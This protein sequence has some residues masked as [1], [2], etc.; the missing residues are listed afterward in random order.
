M[1][2]HFSTA[3]RLS[4]SSAS[5]GGGPDFRFLPRSVPRLGP[6]S[7]GGAEHAA[8][9]DT[10]AT[11]GGRATTTARLA[12]A[13]GTATRTGPFPRHSAASTAASQ[14]LHTPSSQAMRSN[15]TRQARGLVPPTHP[16]W[17]EM[18]SVNLLVASNAI[19]LL[20]LIFVEAGYYPRTCFLR[21]KRQAITPFIQRAA[22]RTQ[23]HIVARC[24][25]APIPGMPCAMG[26]RPGWPPTPPFRSR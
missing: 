21:V 3:A 2:L 14:Q 16:A 25:A 18:A 26:R 10:A 7:T 9:A 12:A 6:A 11:A 5:P 22:P 8:P 13:P 19:D 24:R 4:F 20:T 17:G 23:M 15:P 1:T